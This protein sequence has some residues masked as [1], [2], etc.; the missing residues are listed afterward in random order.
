MIKLVGVTWVTETIIKVYKYPFAKLLNITA[1]DGGLFHKQGNFTR[2]GFIPLS[3]AEAKTKVPADQLS[4]VDYR[5]VLLIM[6]QNLQF[7]LLSSEGSVNACRWDNPTGA[8]RIAS[9]RMDALQD[10]GG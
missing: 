1:V 4:D 5:D 9:L 2:H 6:H 7:S 10:R 3:D 8:T